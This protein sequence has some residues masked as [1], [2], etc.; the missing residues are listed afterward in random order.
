MMK[1]RD[2]I[3]LVENDGWYY[4]HSTGSH[5]KNRHQVKKGAVTIAGKPGSDLHPEILNSI[6]KQ[7]QIVI[8]K[9]NQNK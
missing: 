1:I 7:A 4:V 3:K 5:R 6:L 8:P 2:V 9:N